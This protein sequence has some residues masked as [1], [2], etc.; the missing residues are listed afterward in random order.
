M[1]QVQQKIVV[2]D[3]HGLKQTC[4]NYQQCWLGEEVIDFYI[5]QLYKLTRNDVHQKKEVQGC[6][7]LGNKDETKQ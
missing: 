7:M 5:N 6:A 3:Q 4:I 2:Q 1:A